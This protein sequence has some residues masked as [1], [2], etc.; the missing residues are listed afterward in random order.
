MALGGHHALC[1]LYCD[2]RPQALDVLECKAGGG[3]AI[4]GEHECLAHLRDAN[5]K[6]RSL[7]AKWNVSGVDA[8][9]QRQRLEG[10]QHQLMHIQGCTQV[11]SHRL[12]VWG[13]VGESKRAR[14]VSNCWVSMA[15][16]MA[17]RLPRPAGWEQDALVR[18]LHLGGELR[19]GVQEGAAGGGDGD[20]PGGHD[21]WS[22]VCDCVC[23]CVCVCAR[24][25]VCA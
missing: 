12:S 11:V 10:K 17:H 7:N 13:N 19:V 6:A 24:E 16:T 23:V 21:L 20:G 14:L 15:R 25:S 2:G 8:G 9:R 1:G 5:W 18:Q 22:C 4:I 3:V